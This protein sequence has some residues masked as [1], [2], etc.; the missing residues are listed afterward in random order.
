LDDSECFHLSTAALDPATAAD[1]CGLVVAG[2]LPR[3]E[4]WRV[5]VP[6][7]S[8][9]DDDPADRT[10]SAGEF[11]RRDAPPADAI[12]LADLIADSGP[13]P[14]DAA[15]EC[16]QRLAEQLTTTGQTGSESLEPDDVLIDD[17]G[18]VWL[19]DRFTDELAA[20]PVSERMD[21][22]GRLLAFLATGDNHHLADGSVVDLATL[23]PPLSAVAGRLFSQNGSCY[24][25]YADLARDAAVL[26]GTQ[27]NLAGLTNFGDETSLETT[28]LAVPVVEPARLAA[29]S[30]APATVAP[31]A[32]AEVARHARQA[33]KAAEEE[34]ASSGSASIGMGL[35]IVIAVLLS[36][37]VAF[38]LWRVL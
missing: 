10:S 25:D 8:R 28:P 12:S 4:G 38:V 2:N 5:T 9:P 23:P 6:S 31:D 11:A 15:L 1:G 29:A 19:R 27:A 14:P 17:D 35:A 37:I 24:R 21:R 26:R 22:L 16:V 18:G 32:S 20:R 3:F 7:A 36:A 34:A 13:L 33:D 30:S